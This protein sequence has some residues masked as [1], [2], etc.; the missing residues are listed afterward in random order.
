MNGRSLE[1]IN[2]S[3]SPF[4][5][6]ATHHTQMTAVQQKVYV[7]GI[8]ADQVVRKVGSLK[9]NGLKSSVEQVVGS[10]CHTTIQSV[11]KTFELDQADALDAQFCKTRIYP[12]GR[13]R[14]Y[15]SKR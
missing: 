11:N 4:S 2:L 3:H 1:I 6:P 13:K 12:P 5:H 15:I 10:L 7:E 9:N 8:F 14:I